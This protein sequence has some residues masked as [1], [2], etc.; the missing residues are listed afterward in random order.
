M[1]SAIQAEI[2]ICSYQKTSHAKQKERE[3]ERR[4][5]ER[6]RERE[7]EIEH[8]CERKTE[9]VHAREK[10]RKV[11]KVFLRRNFISNMVLFK[12]N[13]LVLA[14]IKIST[15]IS[16]VLSGYFAQN[17]ARIRHRNSSH[18]VLK[19]L[20]ILFFFNTPRR[21]LTCLDPHTGNNE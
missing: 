12:Y 10:E 21:I 3:R 1:E 6:E 17:F 18:H 7:G 8:P 5:R 20:N 16:L 14:E 9:S 13:V 2:V 4:C 11:L 15:I 19:L